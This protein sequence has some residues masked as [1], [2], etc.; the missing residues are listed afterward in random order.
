MEMFL[1]KKKKKREKGRDTHMSVP[2]H[3]VVGELD[4]LEG[5]DL[6][7]ELLTRERRVRMDVEPC[8]CRR[9]RLSGHQPAAP[10]ICVP[11]PLIVDRHDVHQ[12]GVSAVRLQPV[13]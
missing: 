3:V 13:E 5:D 6:L 1:L 4:F 8:R 9:I 11:I 12:N 10:V 2:V 7:S